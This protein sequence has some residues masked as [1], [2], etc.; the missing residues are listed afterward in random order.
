MISS[1]EEIRLF[2]ASQLLKFAFSD[3]PWSD[4]DDGFISYL[5]SHRLL[6]VVGTKKQFLFTGFETD[7]VINAIHTRT[8]KAMNDSEYSALFNL[9]SISHGS[10]ISLTDDISHCFAPF[11]PHPRFFNKVFLN[12]VKSGK[13]TSLQEL[14]EYAANFLV[15]NVDCVAIV[16]DLIGNGAM[17]EA[18]GTLEILECKYLSGF[19]G[20]EKRRLL[21]NAF[22][23]MNFKDTLYLFFLVSITKIQNT[24]NPV[25]QGSVQETSSTSESTA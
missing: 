3:K 24:R 10:V 16:N 4:K 2:R 6:V 14:E 22:T 9:T 17:L 13:A 25:F 11:I 7:V 12:L 19:Y 20:V 15:P 8:D 5:T 18:N 23:S 1:P 21:A